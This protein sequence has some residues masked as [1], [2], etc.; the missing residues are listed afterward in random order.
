MSYND[1]DKKLL[2]TLID[3][4]DLYQNAPCGYLSF[5]PDGTIIKVNKTLANW[6]GYAYDEIL[7]KKKFTDLITKGGA[8]H[9]EMFFRPLISANGLVNQLSYDIIK[10]DKGTFPVFLSAVASKTTEGR[11][12]AINATLYDVRERKMYE[13]E[14]LLAKEKADAE[15]KRFEFLSDFNPEIIWTANSNGDIDYVNKRYY[16]YFNTLQFSTKEALLKV[17]PRD[18][19]KLLRIWINS[20]QTGSTFTVEI[21][22]ENHSGAYEWHLIKAAVYMEENGTAARW[23]GSCT[24]IDA[25]VLSIQKRDEFINIASHELKTPIT[26]L[27]A[28]NQILQ[29]MSL[30]SAANS[31]LSRANTS[32]N[33]LQFLVSTLLDVSKIDSGQ[34]SLNLSSFSMKEVVEEAVELLSTS[35]PTHTVIKNMDLHNLYLVYADRQ[36]IMQVIINLISNAIKYSPNADQVEVSLIRSENEKLIKF[37]V[38]DYGAGIPEDKL[39]QIFEKYYRVSD[40]KNNNKA[41]GLGLGLYIIHNIIKQHQSRIFVSS[42][43]NKGSCFYFSL[44]AS[45]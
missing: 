21:R 19:L 17:Y 33:S 44:P 29:R 43:L 42:T 8:L 32:L 10:K 31:F 28:Y 20:I 5:L 30:P 24:N 26:S 40:T 4:E 12:Q 27:K 35:Y 1:I 9:F 13:Q 14:L 38:R 23:I 7:Y 3:P 37:E 41:T 16:Q 11:V 22:L 36:R 15:R 45:S 2:D 18:R 39:E 6:L 34:L 25:Q